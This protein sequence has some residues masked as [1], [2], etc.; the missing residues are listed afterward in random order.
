MNA[1]YLPDQNAFALVAYLR[2]PLRS[3]LLG[4]RQKL[5]LEVS[6][7]PHITILPP[8]PLTLP[9]AEATRKLAAILEGWQSFGVEL[10]DLEVFSGSNVL[11]LEVGEGCA[12]MEQLHAELDS[13]DFSH[14]E[15]FPFH[16]HVTVG[17]LA[18]ADQVE[19][20][21]RK[22]AAAWES[23][24]CVRRFVIDELTLVG[25][26]EDAPCSN[27]QQLWSYTLRP[28]DVKKKPAVAAALE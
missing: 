22:A 12:T 26:A 23:T 3:W 8:R 20:T 19:S 2:D 18:D 24:K 10:A 17:E 21:L 14:E 13:G 9:L 28:A 4:L 5:S 1:T 6:S 11:F 7:Q 25:L 16:P 15:L 27:W